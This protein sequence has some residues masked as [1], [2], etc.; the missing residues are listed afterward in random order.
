MSCR[1]LDELVIVVHNPTLEPSDH[2]WE[3]YVAWS[4]RILAQHGK[5]RVLVLA[6]AK[7][8]TSKQRSHYN[9]EIA[10]DGVR[11]AILLTDKRLLAVVKVFSWFLRNV[12]PFETHDVAGAAA[13]LEVAHAE[14]IDVALAELS[15]GWPV[16]AKS[17]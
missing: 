9:Q 10:G 3:N 8:P 16:A 14:A 13:Y 17:S 4:K 5:L 2:E 12:K 1:H 7:A 6:G 11:I 15:S